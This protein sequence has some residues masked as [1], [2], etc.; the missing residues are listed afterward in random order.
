VVG[1]KLKLCDRGGSNRRPPPRLYKGDSNSAAKL[2]LRHVT[3]FHSQICIKRITL[4][5][6]SRLIKTVQTIQIPFIAYDKDQNRS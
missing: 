3:P 1:G 2:C 4:E 6:L 5:S